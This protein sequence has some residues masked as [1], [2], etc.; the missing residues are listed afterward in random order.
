MASR[1]EKLV[2]T[3]GSGRL[4]HYVVDLLGTLAA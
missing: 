1:F 4:G 3:G 2:C